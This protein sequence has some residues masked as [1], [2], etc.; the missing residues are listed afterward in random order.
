MP[1]VTR[2]V[3]TPSRAAATFWAF[4]CALGSRASVTEET[5]A[6]GPCVTAASRIARPS[7]SAALTAASRLTISVSARPC[8]ASGLRAVSV[9]ID[10]ARTLLEIPENA[11]DL[12]HGA[13]EVFCD[14]SLQHVRV[15]Q[16]GGIL[17]RVVLQP[18]DVE[19]ALVPRHDLVV[20]EGAPTSFS[21]LLLVP[22]RLTLVAV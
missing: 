12:L 22:R 9:P 16:L 7:F 5:P 13:A 21:V 20:G 1:P 8:A 19:A 6:Y 14:L 3:A 2:C 15:W 10:E 11:L 17:Q 18:E 4:T